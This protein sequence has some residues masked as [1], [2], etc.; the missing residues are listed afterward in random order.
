MIYSFRIEG[1]LPSAND[2]IK[3][4]RGNRYGGN[5][6]VSDTEKYIALF[7]KKIPHIDRPVI[8]H[9]KW[10]EK[11]RKRDVDNVAFAKKFIIDT[12]VK[13][14]KLT[15]DSSK[16]VIGFTDRFFY[17]GTAHVD[18]DIEEILQMKK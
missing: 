3:L 6:M 7:I 17:N 4:C 16:Y 13:T 5:K 2:Y 15:D 14:K 18:V 12:L 11:N 9:F 8:L 1:K 10:Y